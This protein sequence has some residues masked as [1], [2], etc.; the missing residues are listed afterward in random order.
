MLRP[1]ALV[2][3]LAAP[4][5][6]A[7]MIVN[8]PVQTSIQKVNLSV[9]TLHTKF[10]KLQMVQD[11]ITLKNNYLAAKRFYD[12]IEAKSRHRGG[13]MG[14]Y[15]DYAKEQFKA[16]AEQEWARLYAEGTS[17]TGPAA[18][19]DLINGVFGAVNQKVGG[20]IDSAEGAVAEG[21]AV[22]DRGYANVRHSLFSQQKRQTEAVDKMVASS[23]KGAAATNKQIQ[24]LV[25]RGSA[26]Q[27]DDKASDSI[28]MQAAILQV[29]LLSQIRQLLN[30]NAQINNFQAKQGMAE[31][32]VG[33]ATANDLAEYRAQA[34]K[35]RRSAAASRSR[36][37]T[38]LGRP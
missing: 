15:A 31:E 11:A 10:M 8:D 4:A 37:A 7:V 19:E 3:F 29:Q 14:Y 28:Q 21:M 6:P 32:A 9:Q 35:S 24:D 25:R 23:E 26:A 22:P 12:N 33:M 38:V 34:A 5:R 18:V 30:L 13:L 1:L 36:L 27:I 17:Q 2:L 20:V 16:M